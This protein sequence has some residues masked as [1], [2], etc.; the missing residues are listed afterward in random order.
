MRMQSRIGVL[1][2]A[3]VVGVGA[4]AMTASAEA[5]AVVDAVQARALEKSGATF[6]DVRSHEEWADGHLKSALHLPV[7]QVGQRAASLLPDK[8]RALVLYC[9]SGARA[10]QAANVLRG[11][12]YTRVTVMS[13]GFGDM[14]AAGYAVTP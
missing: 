5:P 7:D 12:G 4:V 11:L 14:K 3:A 2:A 8:N 10:Q 9:R 13:G 6:V 1:A